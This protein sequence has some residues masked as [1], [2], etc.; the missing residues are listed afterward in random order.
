MSPRDLLTIWK[1]LDRGLR[2]QF[3]QALPL[4]LAAFMMAVMLGSV[5]LISTV[6][7]VVEFA[8]LHD[9][10]YPGM[11]DEDFTR[12]L[13]ISE[14]TLQA[15]RAAASLGNSPAA[16]VASDAALQR[17][18]TLAA[19]YRQHCAEQRWQAAF[20]AGARERGVPPATSPE[21]WLAADRF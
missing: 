16:G 13:D 4:L 7:R 11:S 6:M 9:S 10:P 19:D 21:T 1:Q 12:C 15:R 14:Q 5:M 2:R 17:V 20:E 18:E 8:Q 3:F